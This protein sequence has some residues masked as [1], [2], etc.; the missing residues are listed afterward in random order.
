M[1]GSLCLTICSGC[2]ISEAMPCRSLEHPR[3]WQD[4]AESFCHHNRRKL[5][6]ITCTIG[7]GEKRALGWCVSTA[8]A[9]LNSILEASIVTQCLL[10]VKVGYLCLVLLGTG[11]YSWLAAGKHTLCRYLKK[12]RVFI[13]C[14]KVAV[15]CAVDSVMLC[16]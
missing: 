9:Y 13:R 6:E 16:R 7:H 14:L 11:K 2:L 15:E 3:L 10:Q 1:K 4:F 12:L 5:I 8:V